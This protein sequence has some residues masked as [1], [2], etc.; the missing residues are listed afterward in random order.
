MNMVKI[1]VSS[2]S[3]FAA[4]VCLVRYVGA[5]CWVWAIAACAGP[6]KAEPLA[7]TVRAYNDAVRWQRFQVAAAHV[8][9]SR[10]DHFLDQRDRI[11]DDLRINDYEVIRVRYDQNGSR[12]RVHVKFVWHRDSE[13]IVRDT[14]AVQTW[15]RQG[16]HWLL[17]RETHLRGAPM[18]G[19]E[20]PQGD[21]SG[22]DAGDSLRPPEQ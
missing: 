14:H 6:G 7:N 9:A 18:P 22:P 2:S 1:A 17:M 3:Y 13:G 16:K 12:A 5:L 10:Q 19:V 20:S 4:G 11:H 8:P 15:H 21:E